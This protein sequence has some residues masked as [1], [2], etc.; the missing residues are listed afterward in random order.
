LTTNKTCAGP[1]N[2][3]GGTITWQDNSD[4]ETGFRI[5][6]GAN[7]HGTVGPN[8]TT[9][10]IPPVVTNDPTITLSVEAYNS[11][12]TSAKV[13]IVVAC[14][15]HPHDVKNE[16]PRCLKARGA[17]LYFPLTFPF[18]RSAQ[19][20]PQNSQKAKHDQDRLCEPPAKD[21]P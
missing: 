1:P 7:P 21:R 10:P 18:S 5:Y 19:H 2:T 3:Y 20:Q 9:Y 15:Q 14:P 8:V 17:F 16:T 12:G 11:D 4:N 13:S 6:F